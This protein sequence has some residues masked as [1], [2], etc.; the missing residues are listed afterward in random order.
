[1]NRV[2]KDEISQLPEKYRPL[3]MWSIIGW[4]IL[5]N[6]FFGISFI[7][8]LVFAF[9]RG[10][11]NRRSLARFWLLLKLLGLLAIALVIVV[12]IVTGVMDG[13]IASIQDFLSQIIPG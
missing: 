10:N 12:L 7:L 4:N 1:M 6:A 13:I 8:T 11:I 5:F 9:N 3:T 2:E